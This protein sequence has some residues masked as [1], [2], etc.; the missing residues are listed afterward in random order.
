MKYEDTVALA[1]KYKKLKPFIRLGL[2]N[3]FIN[4]P[5][6]KE[7]YEKAYTKYIKEKKKVD[8]EETEKPSKSKSK[9][10]VKGS[11]D[12]EVDDDAVE[13]SKDDISIHWDEKLIKGNTKYI[14]E[15]KV[16][17][18]TPRFNSWTVSGWDEGKY[19]YVASEQG[20]EV[21]I[22]SLQE[23]LPKVMPTSEVIDRPTSEEVDKLNEVSLLNDWVGEKMENGKL[24]MLAVDYER[25]QA[26]AAKHDAD[27]LVLLSVSSIKGRKDKSTLATSILLGVL[28]WPTL[29]FIIYYYAK[30]EYSTHMYYITL[31]FKQDKIIDTTHKKIKSKTSKSQVKSQIYAHLLNLKTI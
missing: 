26:V 22:K 19:N 1:T 23:I 4:D 27:N 10:D 2:L 8:E 7:V 30:P 29:P 17:M 24:T 16:M 31:N 9:K 28:L 11:S 15:G 14:G 13:A 3:L 21:M 6:F 12:E 5:E 18:L 25:V 20:K